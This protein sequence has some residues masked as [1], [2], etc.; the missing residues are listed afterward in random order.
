M[1]FKFLGQVREAMPLEG[2]GLGTRVSTHLARRCAVA[3][4]LGLNKLVHGLHHRALIKG[5]QIDAVRWVEG[6]GRRRCLL[7]STHDRL[8]SIPAHVRGA[9]LSDEGCL[10]SLHSRCLLMAATERLL[11]IVSQIDYDWL[12]LCTLLVLLASRRREKHTCLRGGVGCHGGRR[13]GRDHAT[14]NIDH[15]RPLLESFRARH[16]AIYLRGGLHG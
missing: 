15:W 2:L 6:S 3:D 4:L 1:A 12:G 13:Q 16:V 9:P 14:R 11:L 5:L 8:V 10:L 7:R